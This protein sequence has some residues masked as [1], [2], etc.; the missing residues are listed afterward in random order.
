MSHSFIKRTDVNSYL[1]WLSA[2]GR[3]RIDNRVYCLFQLFD[4][5][6]LLQ[7]RMSAKRRREPARS[8]VGDEQ[9]R[10]LPSLQE[11]RDRINA[12]AVDADVEDREVELGYHRESARIA[13][14]GGSRNDAMTEFL[15]H[16][17]YGL[18]SLQVIIY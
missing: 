8:G 18:A 12:I 17:R 14:C 1:T 13:N 5:D 3:S 4:R 9:D 7:H 2:S 16:S 15:N 11:V 10:S 6:R